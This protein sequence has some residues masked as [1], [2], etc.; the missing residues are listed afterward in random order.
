VQGDGE[1][2]KWERNS[3]EIPVVSLHRGWKGITDK[4]VMEGR[5]SKSAL[6]AI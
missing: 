3:G 4:K 5:E 1:G 2:S 6:Q